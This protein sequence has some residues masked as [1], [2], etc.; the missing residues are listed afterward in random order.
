MLFF[1]GLPFVA[2]VQGQ[3]GSDSVSLG[4][5]S[6]V[7]RDHDSVFAKG[8]FGER[9]RDER[10]LRQDGRVAVD[11]Q[12]RMEQLDQPEPREPERRDERGHER[13]HRE[14][15]HAH[16]HGFAHHDRAHKE[17]KGHHV[18]P[19]WP[20]AL[21]QSAERQFRRLQATVASAATS[22]AGGAAAE[23][24]E[25]PWGAPKDH[26]IN[27]A[28]GDQE[29]TCD[30][31]EVRFG[32]EGDL[33]AGGSHSPSWTHPVK[34]GDKESV[35]CTIDALRELMVQVPATEGADV[36]L[37]CGCIER[38]VK[39]EF[40]LGVQ[41]SLLE[42][43]EQGSTNKVC[44][45]PRE[46]ATD[47]NLRSLAQ[48]SKEDPKE[49]EPSWEAKAAMVTHAEG[50]HSDVILEE[51]DD[52]ALY[53]EWIW[54]LSSGQIKNRESGKCLTAD[55]HS[56]RGIEQIKV[57]ECSL[58]DSQLH[59]Q[60]WEIPMYTAPDFE[61]ADGIM[62]LAYGGHEKAG[63]C[64]STDEQD[65]YLE[66]CHDISGSISWHWQSVKSHTWEGCGSV[67][68]NCY[69]AGEVRI[70]DPDK[71][72]WSSG[73]PVG[74]GESDADGN[75]LKDQMTCSV[76]KLRESS[77]EMPDVTAITTANEAECQCRHDPIMDGDGTPAAAEK[78][79]LEETPEADMTEPQKK[80]SG[81]NSMMVYG[82][83]GGVVLVLAAGA[84][85]FMT[86]KGGMHDAYGEGEFEEEYEEEYEE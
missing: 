60:R 28:Y 31:G 17:H 61:E 10:D 39:V 27:C 42:G 82:A 26:Y 43:G 57:T 66:N 80:K 68:S 18:A 73:V 29:C 4:E 56:D 14:R 71:E 76:A 13:G 37:E 12:G 30:T 70:G 11:A 86:H 16:H 40:D 5:S 55:F 3:W 84:F 54:F 44:M 74:E 45:V 8:G 41:A 34:L 59:T 69:C 32:T 52:D 15:S 75:T 50:E 77:V 33:A 51:C 58:I 36:P 23:P 6:D 19:S 49:L 62:R 9:E 64:L 63:L 38:M 83:A 47:V 20:A 35:T 78:L 72:T 7:D 85:F 81:K 25:E 46:H 48:V 21:V 1:F 67:G 22:A 79:E 53:Q 65:I 2:A 24:A